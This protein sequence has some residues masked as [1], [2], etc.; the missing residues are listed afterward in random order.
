[1]KRV[2]LKLD[3]RRRM[4]T[5]DGRHAVL[6]ERSWQVLALLL[7]RSP[8]VVCRREIVDAV[9]SGNSRTGEKGLNQAM[10]AIRAALGDDPREPVF[11]RTVPRVGYQWI[12]ANV[13]GDVSKTTAAS[14][15]VRA[16]AGIAAV[17]VAVATAAYM[18]RSTSVSGAESA[19]GSPEMV[20][21]KAYLVD[22]DIHVEFADGCLGILK[23]A[24]HAEIGAPVLSSDGT[25]VAVTV[26]EAGSCR[27]VTIGVADGERRDF[28]NCPT[29]ARL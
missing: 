24:S 10:W 25:E 3:A 4:V 18:A 14:G 12:F 20:A 11:I 1:M 27:L 26:R 23:N 9:W 15:L 22:R 7:A 28:E 17:A 13:P 5:V 2:S 16:I 6:Q 8:E 19:S 21:T 29:I